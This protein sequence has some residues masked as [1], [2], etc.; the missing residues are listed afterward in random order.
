MV[1][2]QQQQV[3]VFKSN[4]LDLYFKKNAHTHTHT[5]YNRGK[6]FV[7]FSGYLDAPLLSYSPRRNYKQMIGNG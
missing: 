6:V 2:H 7:L 3:K 4:T 1:V 5:S